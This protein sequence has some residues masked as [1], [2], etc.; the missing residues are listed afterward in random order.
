MPLD[1]AT[2][3]DWRFDDVRQRYDQKDTMLYALGNR[4]GMLDEIGRAIEDAGD[5]HL[6]IRQ[7]DVLPDLPLVRMPRIRPF[8][9]QTQRT[10]LEHQR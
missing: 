4:L 2:V 7:A 5:N 6:V 8:K 3:K 1:Y 9:R 10:G